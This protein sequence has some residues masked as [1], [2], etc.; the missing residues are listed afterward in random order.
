M[1]VQ[2]VFGPAPVCLLALAAT[3]PLLFLRP[4]AAAIT[5]AAANALLLAGFGEPTVAGVLAQLIAGYRAAPP[6]R[7]RAAMWPG[8]AGWARARRQAGARPG[9]V[10]APYVGRRG[11]PCRSSCWR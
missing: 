5:I 1:A 6:P 8:A 3:V 10:V 9:S 4:A 2:A 7:V 11:W